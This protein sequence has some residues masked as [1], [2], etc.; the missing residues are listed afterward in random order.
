MYIKKSEAH[1][2]VCSSL[3]HYG[4]AVL[5]TDRQYRCFSAVLAKLLMATNGRAY[6]LYNKK[7]E[8]LISLIFGNKKPHEVIAGHKLIA[9]VQL[10]SVV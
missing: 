9:N 6:I 10:L 7:P 2:K 3:S 5:Y 8:K 4:S 1:Q